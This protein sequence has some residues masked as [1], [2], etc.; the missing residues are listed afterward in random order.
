MVIITTSTYTIYKIHCLN[1]KE[2]CS[3]LDEGVEKTLVTKKTIDDRLYTPNV[4][5]VCRE[6]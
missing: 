3:L 2:L 1:L 5:I 6:R 4:I